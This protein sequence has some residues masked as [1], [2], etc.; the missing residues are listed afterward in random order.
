MD[1][2]EIIASN[3]PQDSAAYE[4][5][6][7]HS[8]LVAQKAL[9]LACNLSHLNPDMDFSYEAAM[10]HAIGIIMT[11]TPKLGCNGA[12]PYICHGYSGRAILE[13]AGLAWHGLVCERPS[14]L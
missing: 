3:C 14:L 8:S 4:N 1:P 9:A 13:K 5:L 7:E 6:V 10:L 2:R 12:L 11:R